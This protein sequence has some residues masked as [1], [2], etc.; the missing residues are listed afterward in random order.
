MEFI[1]P[2]RLRVGDTVAIVS[3][4]WGGP[5]IFPHIYDN[6]LQAL[7]DLGLQIKEYPSA[8]ADNDFLARNPRARAED[9]NDAFADDEVKAIF[10]SIGGDDSIRILPFLEPETIKKNPK[11][12][13]GYS[14]TT[15][16]LTYINQMGL[17]TFSGPSVMAGFSQADAFPESFVELVRAMLFSPQENYE[18]ES[19]GVYCDGYL[20]WRNM[21]NLGK[22]KA[23]KSD[24]G[25]R[26]LQGSEVVTGEL[27]GGCIEVMEMLN[28]TDFWADRGFWNGKVLFFE[29]SEDKPP[30]QRIRRILRNY[31][32]QGIFDSASAVLFGRAR[33]YT[34][35]EKA[36]L[37]QMILEVVKG[38]FGNEKLP[39]VSN[40][41]FGHT[42]PQ[43][44]LP[45]G[46]K[47]EINCDGKTFRL[48][49]SPVQ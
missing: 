18:Y 24:G 21:E 13:M 38:E 42:D 11:I 35:E 7:R 23:L 10:A 1:K 9:I 39:V 43:F 8:R 5:S 47:A 48:L 44:I 31:G 6:G 27:Y 4:S 17:V 25:W 16:L 29:T 14:D 41:D 3:P 49:E 32:M 45:L 2:S 12:L 26:F 30:V 40:M 33:D 28:G 19:Y 36:E 20:D 15:T 37:D 22:A 46:V 34:D